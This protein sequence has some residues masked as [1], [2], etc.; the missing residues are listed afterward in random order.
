MTGKQAI[1]LVQ[2]KKQIQSAG[3]IDGQQASAAHTDLLPFFIWKGKGQDY[4]NETSETLFRKYALR[5][6]IGLLFDS[7]YQNLA[8]VLHL[9]SRYAAE[10]SFGTQT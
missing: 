5:Q 6:M 1:E 10:S 4:S 3:E 2:K 9:K 8:R 7:I